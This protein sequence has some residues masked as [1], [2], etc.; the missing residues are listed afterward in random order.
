MQNYW[1]KRVAAEKDEEM[2]KDLQDDKRRFEID[3]RH[4]V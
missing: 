2:K 3:K 4:C 1:I